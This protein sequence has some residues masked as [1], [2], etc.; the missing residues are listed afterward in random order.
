MDSARGPRP[1]SVVERLFTS[2]YVPLRNTLA[3]GQGDERAAEVADTW[4]ESFER[5]YTE[6]YDALRL[7][8]KRPT[9]VLD[10]PDIAQRIQ[11]LHGARQAQLLMVD[12][13]RFDL[14]LLM[15]ER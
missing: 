2:A 12:S 15:H 14:G 3:R 7:R 1:L 10:T 9:M 11:R 13:M 5:S 6:A 4:A 8:G